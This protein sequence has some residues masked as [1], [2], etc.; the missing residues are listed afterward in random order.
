MMLISLPVEIFRS[1]LYT[2]CVTRPYT[3]KPQEEKQ[4]GVDHDPE[5]EDVDHGDVKHPMLLYI[6]W[7]LVVPH[8]PAGKQHEQK[9]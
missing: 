8:Q 4:L 5:H 7:Q 1:T 3:N 9:L 6:P 2:L